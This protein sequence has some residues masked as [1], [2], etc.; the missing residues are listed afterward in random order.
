MTRL[1]RASGYIDIDR[2]T[3]AGKFM[4]LEQTGCIH[5]RR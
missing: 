2:K 3:F 4:T 5:A 1:E